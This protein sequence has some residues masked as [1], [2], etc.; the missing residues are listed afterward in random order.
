MRV[1]LGNVVEF[2]IKFCLGKSISLRNNLKTSHLSYHQPSCPL[3][4][5]HMSTLFVPPVNQGKSEPLGHCNVITLAGNVQLP[6]CCLP[7]AHSQKES[8]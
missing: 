7:T 3:S 5:W 1:G 4:S 8:Q 2:Y 6:T